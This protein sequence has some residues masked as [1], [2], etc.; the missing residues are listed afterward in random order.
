[1]KPSQLQPEYLDLKALA[2]YSSFSPRSL[3]RI[4]SHPDGPA[5][6]RLSAAGKIIVR[7]SDFDSWMSQFKQQPADF[8]ALINDTLK[9]FGVGR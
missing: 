7:R 3:R 8:D 5:S 1:M 6:Y 4:L 9:G 2:T